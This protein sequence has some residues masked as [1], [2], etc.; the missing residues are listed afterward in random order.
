MNYAER[1]RAEARRL[2]GKART[3]QPASVADLLDAAAELW[4]AME[5]YKQYIPTS[6]AKADKP[7]RHVGNVVSADKFR[8]ALAAADAVAKG[9]E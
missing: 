4:E 9:A 5:Q 1:C 7:M 3:S 6:S 8:D 2:R